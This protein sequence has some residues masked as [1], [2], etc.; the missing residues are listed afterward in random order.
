MPNSSS[1]AWWPLLWI[2][3]A[4][5]VSAS[6][7]VG[8]GWQQDV[9]DGI[10]ARELGNM[11]DSI[12]ALQR[13]ALETPD[14]V[15]RVYARTELGVSLAQTGRL[16]EAQAALELAY[17]DADSAARSQVA[18]ALGNLALRSHD[19]PQAG[20]YYREAIASA[21]AGE[22]GEDAKVSAELN[23]DGLQPPLQRLADLERLSSRIDSMSNPSERARAQF[24]LGVEATEALEQAQL[25][26]SPEFDRALPLSYRALHSAGQ[27]AQ[28]AGDVALAVDAADAIAQLYES[29]GRLADADEIN[30]GAIVAAGGLPQGQ[31]QLRLVRLEWRAARLAQR[32]GE[33]ALAIAHYMRA[34]QRLEAIHQDLPIEDA[35]GRSTFQSL[36]RPII[37]GLTDLLLQ[38][39]DA[40]APDAQ[41]ARLASA[42]RL[43]EQA[44]QAELQ[45]YLGD[46]CS[47]ESVRPSG[48][49]A[50]APGVAL[51][52]PIVL[53][54]RLEVIVRTHDALL[55][56]A[57][58]VSAAALA[59][60]IQSFR[61]ALL[62]VGSSDY[63]QSAQRLHAWLI[64]PFAAAL[65]QAGVHAL[66]IVP[67]GYLRLIPFAALHDGQEF[68][69]QRYW[70]S[71]VTGMS[72]TE[73]AAPRRKRSESL[74]VG[75]SM[76]G[77]V[78]DRL[79]ALGFN[80]GAGPSGSADRRAL[81]DSGAEPP[82]AVSLATR[83]L[84][85][86]SQL[87]L[88]GVQ[89]EIQDLVPLRRSVWLLNDQFTVERFEHE[90]QSG[91]YSV[92]HIA[93]HSFFGGNA[94]ESF[95]LAYDNVIRIDQ[96][97]QLIAVNDS[98]EAG[99]D[100]LTLSACDTATGDERAPLGFAGAA[101]KARARSV[102]GSLWPVNDTATQQFMELF[103][104]GLAQHGKSQAFTE[105]QRALM[106][107]TQFAHPYFWAP[108]ILTG[109][110]N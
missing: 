109:D 103:Y 10:H 42:L 99:I 5:M 18:L 78:V 15:S 70:I 107:S 88:P 7:A 63:L 22:A 32:R 38:G 65:A 101:I 1:P 21:P 104:G 61:S 82:P 13:A 57:A 58:P 35:R 90:V 76:P 106:K 43:T 50:V 81:Q 92:V 36:Q 9:R 89:T 27:W 84:T 17:Q 110:W 94:G 33:S 80:G 60:E 3:S 14:P 87:A 31:A 25:T 85:L 72:M 45:D 95:L 86:R 28:Q 37:A 6:P 12:A 46:R 105:A 74:F 75:L 62:D 44:H 69:A 48:T 71:T 79:L 77:P 64:A 19:N 41:Q 91:N 16:A 49:E 8:T 26:R 59:A 73:P 54:D 96:L 11:N 51:I 56:H 66:V 30:R 52:Y 4:S 53:K 40:L 68:L 20:R 67:D 39:I 29:Q 55:H 24:G 100:L 47:V 102:L 93:S 23:L 2:F 98:S 108:F 97:Q 83:E 34:T